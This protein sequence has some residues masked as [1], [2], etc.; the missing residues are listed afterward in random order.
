MLS[1]SL[2]SGDADGTP[3]YKRSMAVLVAVVAAML[4]GYVNLA[5]AW[6]RHRRS[7]ALLLALKGEPWANE[8]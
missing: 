3:G 4:G 8:C 2:C 1:R 7:A 5:G 6:V